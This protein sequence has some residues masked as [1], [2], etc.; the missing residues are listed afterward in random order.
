MKFVEDQ[1]RT[2]ATIAT[3]RNR[4]AKV[5]QG[6]RHAK[7]QRN[8][9]IQQMNKIAGKSA[10]SPALTNKIVTLTKRANSSGAAMERRGG[11]WNSRSGVGDGVAF[12]LHRKA[13]AALDTAERPANPKTYGRG[14][15]V[16]PKGDVRSVRDK[17]RL[18]WGE[19]KREKRRQSQ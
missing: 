3:R 8:Q 17:P 12:K 9:T 5:L 2:D 13:R 15:P 4:L 6:Y 16:G 14:D 1:R 7:Q 19:H 10:D 18:N 11:A